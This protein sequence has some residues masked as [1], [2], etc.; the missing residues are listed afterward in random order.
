MQR[1]LYGGHSPINLSRVTVSRSNRSEGGQFLGRY[2]VRSGFKTSAE[3]GHLTASWYREN[4]DPFVESATQ[5]PFFFAWRPETFPDEVAYCWTDGDIQ[6][7]NMGIKTLMS[8]GININAAG[9]YEIGERAAPPAISP[10]EIDGFADLSEVSVS[11]ISGTYDDILI[12]DADTVAESSTIS[13]EPLS[14]AYTDISVD[15]HDNSADSSTLSAAPSSGAYTDVAVDAH[16]NSS[17][18][19]TLAITV[20]GGTYEEVVV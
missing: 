7:A 18:N 3:W 17:D 12:N 1:G 14:G 16:D 9:E 13:T 20:A 4:F 8:V 2:I 15:A 6:P 5:Y 11:P 10:S 19:S